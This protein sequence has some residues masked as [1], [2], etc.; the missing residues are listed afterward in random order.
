MKKRIKGKR[1]GWNGCGFGLFEHRGRKNPRT[2]VETIRI[3]SWRYMM[4]YMNNGECLSAILFHTLCENF[5]NSDVAKFVQ[6]KFRFHIIPLAD[7][8][9]ISNVV[10]R[11]IGRVKRVH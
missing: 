9:F 11:V 1:R 7:G 4:G 5:W 3:K 8:N 2:T 10:G 6:T